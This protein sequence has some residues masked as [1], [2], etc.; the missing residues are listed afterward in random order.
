M[1]FRKLSCLVTII[2]NIITIE[3]VPAYARKV[4]HPL[5]N[6]HETKWTLHVKRESDVAQSYISSVLI[7][8]LCVGVIIV[9]TFCEGLIVVIT[10]REGLILVITLCVVMILGITLCVVILV[11]TLCV[12][13]MRFLSS[14]CV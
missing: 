11:I 6:V 7:I 14:F 4:V 1:L 10:V 5:T 3:I 12:G 2:C 9:I 8:T 13:S